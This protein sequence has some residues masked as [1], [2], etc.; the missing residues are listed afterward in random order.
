MEEIDN[1]RTGRL[2]TL[3]A[4]LEQIECGMD[5]EDYD[6]ASEAIE[7]AILSL[8]EI[9]KCERHETTEEERE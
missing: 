7:T 2:E 3:L 4:L 8:T 1:I 9:I 6:T 5:E